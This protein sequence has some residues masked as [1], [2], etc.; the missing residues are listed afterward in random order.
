[1]PAPITVAAIEADPQYV[2][3]DGEGHTFEHY[4]LTFPPEAWALIREGRA[5]L[6]CWEPQ[7]IA[8]FLATDQQIRRAKEKHLPG[9]VY[10]GC[11]GIQHKQRADIAAEFYGEKWV[12]PKQ[13]LEDTIAEDDERR[14]KYQMDTGVKPGPWVPP[15]VR[16]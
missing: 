11:N 15:W 10:G 16:L 5:C 14:A 2:Y 12:G 1:M 6:R 8:F 9:C 13:K 7:E 4:D 3:D